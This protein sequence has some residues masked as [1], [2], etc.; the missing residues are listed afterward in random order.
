MN[1]V[2]AIC[3]AG[4]A[5]VVASYFLN[6][7]KIDKWVWLAAVA[8]SIV[9]AFLLSSRGEAV[10]ELVLGKWVTVRMREVQRMRDDVFA[11]AEAVKRL[12]EKTAELTVYNVRS[13]GRLAPEFPEY[14]RRMLSARDEVVTMLR[15]VGSD[16][17]RIENIVEPV[18][19]TALSD[20]KGEVRSY[21]QR[22]VHEINMAT[23]GNLD[24]Q[25]IWNE[26]RPLVQEYDRVRLTERARALGVHSSGLTRFSTRSTSSSR[27]NRSDYGALVS[28]ARTR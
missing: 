9:V 13:A 20:I 25:A 21:V 5:V 7:G 2:V 23:K 14:V 17:E 12:A 22:R 26:L 18:N 19:Q 27:Q 10:Q 8:G 24:S 16:T 3:L 11:K 28:R 1:N 15:D 6:A 4:C